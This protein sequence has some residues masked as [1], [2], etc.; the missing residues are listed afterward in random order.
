MLC[1]AERSGQCVE[2][3]QLQLV[4]EAQLLLVVGALG[5][6]DEQA[7]REQLKLLAQTLV[8]RA[9]VVA[10]LLEVRDS[11]RRLRTLGRNCFALRVQ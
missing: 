10:L 8:R 7:T 1:N 9:Q 11:L 6:R 3:A 2:L 4:L 5:L